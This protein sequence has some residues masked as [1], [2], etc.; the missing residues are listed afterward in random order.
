[1]PRKDVTRF[2]GLQRPEPVPRGENM[3]ANFIWYG[4]EPTEPPNRIYARIDRIEPEFADPDEPITVVFDGVDANQFDNV[5]GRFRIDYAQISVLEV[6]YFDPGLRRVP[7]DEVDEK[8]NYWFEIRITSSRT[9]VR[10]RQYTNLFG[11]PIKRFLEGIKTID[12]YVLKGDLDDA[13]SLKKTSRRT[14]GGNSSCPRL[15]PRDHR[16]GRL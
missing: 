2:C 1:M 14:R 3:G 10:L 7:L 8:G 11:P 13:I 16:R 6:D 12:D 9:P 15:R 5:R 4:G